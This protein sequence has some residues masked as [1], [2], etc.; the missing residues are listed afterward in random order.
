MKTKIIRYI[1]YHGNKRYVKIKNGKV[2]HSPLLP[3]QKQI[4]ICQ[5][6]I[7]YQCFIYGVEYE[8][9]NNYSLAAALLNLS[10]I[11]LPIPIAGIRFAMITSGF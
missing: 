10:L 7:V 9:T 3:I 11:V 2:L 5:K 4:R 6:N 1:A 8:S